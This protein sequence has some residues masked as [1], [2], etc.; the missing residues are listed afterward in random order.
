MPQGLLPRLN[1]TL[2]AYRQ[3]M[4]TASKS[5]ILGA[6][7]GT[8]DDI[9]RKLLAKHKLGR[10]TIYR[11]AARLH[12]GGEIHISGWRRSVKGSP[13]P[14]YAAG[15]GDDARCRIKPFTEAQKSRRYRGRLKESGEWDAV[16]SLRR[17]RARAASGV[18]D[19]LLAGLFGGPTVYR[20]LLIEGLKDHLPVAAGFRVKTVALV[21]AQLHGEEDISARRTAQAR[22]MLTKGKARG[23]ITTAPG[24]LRSYNFVEVEK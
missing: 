17:A 2:P 1:P 16:C 22:Y 8:R 18:R 14:I 20:A 3:L 6:L 9:E 10:A 15:A 5:L 19:P 12:A 21:L 23:V 11:W 13:V 24:C 4:A 7:P